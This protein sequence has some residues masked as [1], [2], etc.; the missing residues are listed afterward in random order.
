M[1]AFAGV[2]QL[3]KLALR[4]DRLKIPVTIAVLGL[5]FVAQIGGVAN[6]YSTEAER[7]TYALS[8]SASPVAM[9]FNGPVMNTS[10]GAIAF[11]ELF[12][13]FA[14]FV[15][16]ISTLLVVRHTRQNE[17]LGRDELL[18]AGVVGRHA[19]LGAALLLAVAVNIAIGIVIALA[20]TAYG[21]DAAGSL[22]TGC[23]MSGVGIVFAAIA[24]ITAQLGTTARTANGLAAIS[25]GAAFL[26]RAIG[27]IQS[28]VYA[29]GLGATSGWLSWLSPMGIARNARPFADNEWGVLLALAVLTGIC[30]YV[31]FWLADHRDLGAGLFT[32]RRGRLSAKPSLLNVFG[33]AWRLQRGLLAGWTAAF[34]I[35]AWT[36]GAVTKEVGTFMEGN[37][38]GTRIV[39]MLGGSQ[40]LIDA[41]LS[42]ALMIFGIAVAAYTIQAMQRLNVEETSGRLELLLATSTSRPVWVVSHVVVSLLGAALLLVVSGSIAGLAYGITIGEVWQQT[43]A[44]LAACLVYLPVALLFAGLVV[45]LFGTVPRLA[46]GASWTIFV[47]SYIIL[48]FGTILSLPDWLR[49][50][51]PFEHIPRL[52]AEELAIAP[53]WTITLLALVTIGLGL[54]AFARRNSS[55]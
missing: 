24:G 52:P 5:L 44:L 42:F 25:I 51:S 12:T 15:G 22:L 55:N 49:S 9:A 31:A 20:F 17:E 21:L 4:R 33:F 16:L 50:T 47:A 6:V 26:V 8:A 30:M 7:T 53:L 34:A 32:P 36:F 40:N 14:I 3:F 13:F 2:G 19:Q 23:A 11:T 46:I 29:N 28:H 54:L 10:L 37:E 43:S 18:G 48:Q 39:A 38:Q 45:L 35:L 1:S 41:Y 27:D